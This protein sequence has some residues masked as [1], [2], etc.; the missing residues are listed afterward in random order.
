MILR[1]T[2]RAEKIV[3]VPRL[4]YYWRSHEGS[5]AASIDAKPYAIEAAKGAVADHLKSMVSSIF[6]S[7]VPE[8]APRSSESGIRSWEI[9]RSPS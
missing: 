7:P 5:T 8:P 1:L 9:R 6:R 2:D 4:M 3:H